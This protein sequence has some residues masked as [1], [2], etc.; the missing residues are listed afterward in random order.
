MAIAGLRHTENFGTNVRPENW[1]E[2]ILLQY[3][4]GEWP[5]LALTSQMKTE[6][7]DDPAYHWFEKSLDSRRL[8]LGA[9][10]QL[11]CCHGSKI[12]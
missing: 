8:E 7:V 5:L 11:V 12:L 9:N 10:L 4:N 6:K 2:G 1:R 3:P